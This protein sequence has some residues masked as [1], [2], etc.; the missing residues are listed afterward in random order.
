MKFRRNLNLVVHV[1]DPEWAPYWINYKF[2]KKKILQIVKENSGQKY[3]GNHSKRKIASMMSK[4]EAEV[5]FFK[6]L[7]REVKKTSD[8]FNTEEEIYHI[9]ISR[10]ET[11]F[12]YLKENVGKYDEKIWITLLYSCLQFY[13]DMLFLEN[14]AVMNY[15]G[16]SKILKKHDKHTGYAF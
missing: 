8:F 14:F 10:V 3:S 11:S 12:R 16:F 1:S 5:E 6:L 7:Q 9:R 2:L 4:S 13:K 15:C